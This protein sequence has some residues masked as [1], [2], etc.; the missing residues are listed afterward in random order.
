MQ[1]IAATRAAGRVGTETTEKDADVHLVDLLLDPIEEALHAIP[2]AA[3]PGVLGGARFALI[4]EEN[5]VLVFLGQVFEGDLDI[6]LVSSRF[7]DEIELALLI[8][9]AFERNDGFI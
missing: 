4:T 5:P 2:I 7:A 6:D 8:V 3:L 9:T 1:S